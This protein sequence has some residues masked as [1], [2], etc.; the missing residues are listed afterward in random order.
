M[1]GEETKVGCRAGLLTRLRKLPNK[2]PLPS[3]FLANVRSIVPKIN[4][5]ELRI[6]TNNFVRNC[7]VMI[8][9]E[10][11]LHPGIPDAAVQL[12]GHTIHHQDCNSE[13]GKRKGGGLCVLLE[14]NTS[15]TRRLLDEAGS[16]L[17][18]ERN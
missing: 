5:L 18:Q 13:S 8:M 1:E 16:L 9:T 7:C 4:E 6:D 14:Q 10:T 12:A 17:N 15:A 2:P 11:W 3:L